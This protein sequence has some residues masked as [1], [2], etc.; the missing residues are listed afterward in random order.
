MSKFSFVS[1]YNVI[2][3]N[4]NP[5]ITNIVKE[6]T[7]VSRGTSGAEQQYENEA[8]KGKVLHINLQD[9]VVAKKAFEAQDA[10]GTR[11]VDS[12]S[13]ELSLPEFIRAFE[14]MAGPNMR[15]QLGHLFMKIDANCD[16][17]VSWDELL[18]YVISQDRNECKPEKHEAQLLRAEI[19]DCP[20]DE[21]HREP[22]C[23]AMF[24]P[25]LFAYVSGGGEREGTL[26]VWDL[27]LQ[28]QVALPVSELKPGIAVNA[29][30]QLTGS[31]GKLA[32]GSAD[33]VLSLYELQDHA[34]SRRWSVHGRIALKD[35]P[36][37]LC[38][39]VHV[40]D[41]SHCLA[42]GTDA[43]TIRIFDAVRLVGMLR[44]DRVRSEALKGIVGIKIVQSALIVTLPLH[45]DW[46]THLEYESSFAALVTSSLDSTVRMTQLDWPP[47]AVPSSEAATKGEALLRV[48]DP[49]HCRNMSTISAHHK[50]VTSF[51]LMSISGRKLCA[52]CGHER[53][54]FVWNVETGDHTRSLIGHRALMR[55]LAYDPGSHLLISLD[56][57]GEMRTWE[58]IS[59]TLVQIIRP[60]SSLE[61][62]SS[63]WF[64]VHQQCLVTTTRWLSIWQPPRKTATQDVLNAAMLAPR[65]HRH[66]LVAALYSHH[67]FLVVS[68]DESGL[69]C[70]WDVRSGHQVFRFEHGSRLSAMQLDETGRKLLTGGSN[71]EVT[72]WNFSSG[73]KLR[74]IS[75]YDVLEGE[76]T[77]LVNV[78]MPRLSYFFA[79]GW[80]R[81]VWMWPDRPKAHG[82]RLAGHTEDIL[83]IA[84]CPPNLI[85]TG[86][87]DGTILVHNVE[88]SAVIRRVPPRKPEDDDDEE[89]DDFLTSRA[90]E[91]LGVLDKERNT[92]PDIALVSGSADGYLRIYSASDMRFL[93]EMKACAAKEGIQT[94][95]TEESSTFVLT[96]DTAGCVKVWDISELAKLWPTS[97]E[98]MQYR[99][100]SA[101][102]M[103]YRSRRALRELF[104]WRAHARPIT[105]VEYLVGIEGVIT[106]SGDCTVRLWT[107]SGEQ[108]GVFG[109]QLPWEVAKRSTWFDS[110]CHVLEGGDHDRVQATTTRLNALAPKTR[111]IRQTSPLK[112]EI[113]KTATAAEKA[114]EHRK[115]YR[116][117]AS[118]LDELDHLGRILNK[119]RRRIVHTPLPPTGAQ[120]KLNA[121]P[122]VV[123]VKRS[124]S[125]PALMPNA[126]ASRAVAPPTGPYH[127][128]GRMWSMTAASFG[129]PQLDVAVPS[130]RASRFV[131]PSP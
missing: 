30:V 61:R 49:K 43:G 131:T 15:E 120:A 125:Y 84:Y 70:V 106:T 62:I 78:E 40:S 126:T 16:G 107:L 103:S 34:G 54:I 11:I 73:E 1:S 19:P 115:A 118:E 55:Q 102:F 28:L 44:E 130:L 38:A 93:D 5:L 127:N 92:L 109:Q 48:A 72:L 8:K 3:K 2:D 6:E 124:T 51:E 111:T 129:A 22:A 121:L 25:K 108:I 36:V 75:N 58:M 113:K 29:I 10:D 17:H 91:A 101:S 89:V 65:G 76:I 37:S 110:T 53:D 112:G 7:S 119:E 99:D 35:M 82:R 94:L 64:N 9:L 47:A 123:Q 66:P 116:L 60:Y 104:S 81:D 67:F 105:H 20:P 117:Q 27:K 90:I 68:G 21:A 31:L 80:S 98:L 18:T 46:V 79:V 24:I 14:K 83:S 33:R 97:L 57:T 69:I 63:I 87:Y 59:Y 52:T 13:S 12:T 71:S 45:K 4:E 77:A 128:K 86:A 42:I 88:S 85:C 74:S 122:P 41:Q 26:R 95:S 96:G 56:A 39:F 32:V 114:Q 23:C 100:P 50:G